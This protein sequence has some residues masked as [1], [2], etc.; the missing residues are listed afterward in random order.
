MNKTC[1]ECKCY[2]MHGGCN[3]VKN[4]LWI[5]STNIACIKFEAKNFTNGD[6]IRQGGDYVLIK[7]A[8]EHRKN[9]CHF[10]VAF[11]KTTSMC[12]KSWNKSCLEQRLD[13]LNAPAGKDT[14]VPTNES[15]GDDE[16]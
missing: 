13:W 11:D 6:R 16:P 4:T 9:P 14:N 5:H 3:K 8:E 12:T 15:E 1:G 10:C 7:Y 2:D